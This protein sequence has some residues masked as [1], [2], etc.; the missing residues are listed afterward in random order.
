M[1]PMRTTACL[2]VLALFV[3]ACGGGTSGTGVAPTTPTPPTPTTYSLTGRVTSAAGPA[4]PGASVSILDGPNAARATSTDS[5]GNY[6]FTALTAS[7]F[8]LSVSAGGFVPKSGPISLSQN[9]TANVALLPSQLY[10]LNG[11]GNQVFDVPTYI[12]KLRVIADYGGSCQNFIM[13]IGGRSI[14]NEILGSC[15]VNTTG[16][17]YD[18]TVNTIGGAGETVN[19]SGIAWQI[20]EWR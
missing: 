16:R 11:S 12:T 13:H 15:S 18:A 8:T 6:S 7:G 3:S 9:V 20:T 1:R 19:S 4:I 17:H 14:A 5:A 10:Q 2:L